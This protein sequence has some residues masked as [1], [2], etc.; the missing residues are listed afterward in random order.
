MFSC[1]CDSACLCVRAEKGKWLGL[2]AQKLV[3]LQ[4]WPMTVTDRAEKQG[5]GHVVMTNITVPRLLVKCAAAAAGVG[6]HVDSTAHVS[7]FIIIKFSMPE[8]KRVVFISHRV[9]LFQGYNILR[10]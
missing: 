3:G 2:S 10:N 7:S 4:T 6:L 8:S 1:V 9:C 5:Q